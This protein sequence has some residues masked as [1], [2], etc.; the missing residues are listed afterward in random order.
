MVYYYDNVLQAFIIVIKICSSV[1]IQSNN[2]FDPYY[3]LL[4]TQLTTPVSV[5][6]KNNF[7]P[8]F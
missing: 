2:S 8:N 7:D 3:G 1:A 6:V 5:L 4:T